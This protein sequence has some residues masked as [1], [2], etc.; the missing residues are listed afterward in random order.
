MAGATDTKNK[1]LAEA[2]A[3]S[4]E[5]RGAKEQ[6]TKKLDETADDDVDDDEDEEDDEDFVS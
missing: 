1:D 4:A 3:V 5:P 2:E 6:A